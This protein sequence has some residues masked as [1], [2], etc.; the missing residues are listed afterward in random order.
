MKLLS[1][2]PFKTRLTIFFSLTLV[3]TLSFIVVPLTKVAT[4]RI[5]EDNRAHLSLLTE[6][7][8]INFDQYMSVQ[9]NSYIICAIH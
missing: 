3:V 6:Q 4:E 2:L 1:R 8:L 7:V 5:L 9:T